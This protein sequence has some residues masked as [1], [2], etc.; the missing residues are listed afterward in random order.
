MVY[1][2]KQ[3][4]L[5]EV[6]KVKREPKSKFDERWAITGLLVL[7]VLASIS[8]YL[9]T[10]I[11]KIWQ[12]WTKPR[13]ISS[14]PV[15]IDPSPVI[16][17]VEDETANLRGTYGF[18]VYQFENGVSF[19]LHE[20]EIFP[21]ASLI[22][23]PVMLTL[24]QEAEEG[25][26]D[27]SDYQEMAEAMGKR[28]DNTAFNSL[29]EVLGEEKIQETIDGLGMRKTSFAKNETTPTDIGL[30]FEKLYQGRIITEAHRDEIL[31]YLTDTAF[32]ERIPAGVP[33]EIQV[34]HKIG[35]DV[36]TY[37]DAGIVFAEKPF[38]LVIISKSARESEAEKVLPKITEA[39]WEFETR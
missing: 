14:L 39:V 33:E 12:E 16:N 36:G 1:R 30:F 20:K 27:L 31:D 32:E 29:V 24:F 15:E 38:I 11:A 18:Y 7:T 9:K 17:K 25:K 3:K 34:A 8:F 23:L 10:E 22:K 5:P 21:A 35:T 26:I 28:S 19:G 13:V 37:S 6:K 2:P 4:E